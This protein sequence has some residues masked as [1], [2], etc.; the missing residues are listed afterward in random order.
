M[1]T[2]TVK[3]QWIAPELV[4]LGRI[5]DVA[6]GPGPIVENILAIRS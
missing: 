4:R 3:K 5:G 2:K 6:G 1:V